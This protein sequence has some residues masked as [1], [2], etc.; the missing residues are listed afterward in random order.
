MFAL[1]SSSGKPELIVHGGA[2]KIADALGIVDW[3]L[4]LTHSQTLAIAF[5]VASAND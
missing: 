4:S 5:V 2:K 1:Q 3:R